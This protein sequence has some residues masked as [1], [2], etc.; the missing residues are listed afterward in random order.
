MELFFLIITNFLEDPPDFMVF[1]GRFH[2]L[3]VHLPIGFLLLAALAQF[4]TRWPKFHPIKPFLVYL[5]A[6]GAIS[7]SLAV[8]F[9]YLLS[10]SGD[11]NED[12]LF[13]HQWSGIIVLVF[14]FIC[15]L[16]SKKQ[17]ENTKLMQWVL[18]ALVTGLM[19]YTG[20]LGGNLTH[21]STYLLDY[22]PNTIRNIAGLPEK[23]ESRPKVIVLDS[24]DVYLDL[25][26]PMM[27][28][29]CVSCHNTGKKK[30]D[31]LLTNYANMMKGGENGEVVIPGDIET[32][33]LFRRI[34]L[35][36]NHDDFMP[37]EGKRPLT[38]Q[39]V[40]IIEWWIVSDAP[41]SGFIT[42]LD[43]EKKITVTVSNYLGLD[44]NTIL[45][46]KVPPADKS[47]TDSLINYGFI[48]NRLMKSNY[49]LEANFSLSEKPISSAHIKLLNS[50]KEQLIWLDLSNAHVSDESLEQI[51][52]LE[53]LIKLDLSGN[54]ISDTGIQ[55]LEKLI[56]LESLNLYNTNVSE[57]ILEIIPK[58]TRLQKIYL[59]QTKVNDSLMRRI[60]S[61]NQNLE[62][63][64]MRKGEIE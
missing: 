10:L 39:E 34:T 3:V 20:H 26:A 41:S 46:K 25:I 40:D 11:Y 47:I 18:I 17:N 19:I 8:V 4:A 30:G 60:H 58:L 21:G 32:S 61:E 9:G 44:K 38:S 48:V 14:S 62:V 49:F 22:A 23:T 6:L 24:A 54:D 57:G 16:I 55:S 2:P 53:N 35:P 28:S 15:Y 27:N 31:L 5:W 43:S 37:S 1:V 50:I 51:G 56:H 33:E 64:S 13:W 52:L 63:I 42:E 36:E 59:W 45:S 29:K 12:T 7:A